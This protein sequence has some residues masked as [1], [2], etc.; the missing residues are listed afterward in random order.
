MFFFCFFFFYVL[1]VSFPTVFVF[2]SLLSSLLATS[3][4]DLLP[5]ESC[6]GL[7]LV[8]GA[9]LESSGP[10]VSFNKDA[11]TDPLALDLVY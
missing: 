2:L 3:L 10:L 4:T 5:C 11:Q 9:P 1:F 8:L 7:F 6:L